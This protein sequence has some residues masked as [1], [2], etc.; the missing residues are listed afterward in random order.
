MVERNKWGQHRSFAI[1]LGEDE[2]TESGVGSGRVPERAINPGTLGER[3]TG[4]EVDANEP[5]FGITRF[6]R[7]VGQYALVLNRSLEDESQFVG[8]QKATFNV[9]QRT[10]SAISRHQSRDLANYAAADDAC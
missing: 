2:S 6:R 7:G 9:Q 3:S 10:A 5:P 8:A 4:R 1:S